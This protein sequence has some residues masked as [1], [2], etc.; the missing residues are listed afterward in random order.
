VI[1]GANAYYANQQSSP[2][3]NRVERFAAN[4]AVPSAMEQSAVQG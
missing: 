3:G 4:T 1:L 2:V